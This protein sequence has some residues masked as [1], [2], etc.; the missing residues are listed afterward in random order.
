MNEQES[1]EKRQAY[2]QMFSLIPRLF[3]NISPMNGRYEASRCSVKSFCTTAIPCTKC[4]QAG[5]IYIAGICLFFV[6]Y[7]FFLFVVFVLFWADLWYMSASLPGTLIN[8]R[9]PH[10]PKGAQNLQ[11]KIASS[12]TNNHDRLKHRP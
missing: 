9:L 12:R 10:K 2:M 5:Q 11:R 1:S 6:K 8:P 7:I 3:I 4:S